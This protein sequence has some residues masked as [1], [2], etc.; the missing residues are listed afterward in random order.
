M[1]QTFMSAIIVAIP[2]CYKKFENYLIR[3]P[4]TWARLEFPTWNDLSYWQGIHIKID[5]RKR[6]TCNMW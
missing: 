5:D 1:K 3:F 4:K 6:Y 2:L